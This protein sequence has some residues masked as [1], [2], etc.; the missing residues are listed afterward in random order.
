MC[1]NTAR[2]RHY[3]IRGVENSL[4]K[5]RSFTLTTE[6]LTQT[7]IVTFLCLLYHGEKSVKKL[8]SKILFKRCT[9]KGETKRELT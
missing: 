9:V 5:L 3:T 6:Q 2:I 1:S 8:I 7:Y 4:R